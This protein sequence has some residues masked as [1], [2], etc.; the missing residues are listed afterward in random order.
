ME[1]PSRY[2]EP[3]VPDMLSAVSS[4]EQVSSDQDREV[5]SDATLDVFPV[6]EQSPDTSYY[7]P[8][9]SPVTPLFL[10]GLLPLRWEPRHL[11][12]TFLRTISPSWCQLI[13]A[14]GPLLLLP[15]NLQLLPD[16]AMEWHSISDSRPLPPEPCSPVVSPP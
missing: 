14:R 4:S 13:V 6:H 15:D 16:I 1:S 7:V 5:G 12:I 8:M 11:W 3:A 9:T 2:L 10:E